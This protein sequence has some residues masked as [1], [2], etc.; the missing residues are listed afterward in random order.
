MHPFV[1]PSAFFLLFP[2]IFSDLRY[3]IFSQNYLNHL[4]LLS[5]LL[6]GFSLQPVAYITIVKSRLLFMYSFSLLKN[7]HRIAFVVLIK[8]SNM[9][10]NKTEKNSMKDF[11]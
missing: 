6:T 10:K 2:F 7:L 4:T 8:K 5:S 3:S 11:F 9:Q 1:K